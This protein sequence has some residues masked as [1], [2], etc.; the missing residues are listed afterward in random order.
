MSR[1]NQ[2]NSPQLFLFPL[3]THKAHRPSGRFGVRI[4]C[5]ICKRPV[6]KTFYAT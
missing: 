4:L 1:F 6:N 3:S 5:P 2:F